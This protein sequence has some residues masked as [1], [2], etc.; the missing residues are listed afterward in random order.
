MFLCLGIWCLLKSSTHFSMLSSLTVPKSSSAATHLG[1]VPLI[2]MS[3]L[4]P[5][6]CEM[7]FLIYPCNCLFRYIICSY[8]HF[9]GVLQEKFKDLKAKGC[10]LIGEMRF[11]LYFLSLNKSIDSVFV[12][13]LNWI[14]VYCVAGPQCALFCAKEGRPLPQRGFTCCLA[15]DGLKVL[16]SGFLVDEKVLLLSV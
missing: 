10:N 3:S 1:V 4:L 14:Y 7:F 13:F 2:S 8:C 6:M 9:F 16:A 15:M 12:N 5:I 11:I